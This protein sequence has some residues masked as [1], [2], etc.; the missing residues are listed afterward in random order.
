MTTSF[1]AAE[2]ALACGTSL[3]KFLSKYYLAEFAQAGIDGFLDFGKDK[4][5]DRIKDARSARKA[6]LAFEGVGTEVLERL[7]SDL[8]SAVLGM[9]EPRPDPNKILRRLQATLTGG[10]ATRFVIRNQIDPQKLADALREATSQS[11]E[12]L[13]EAEQRLFDD[14]ASRAAQY[15]YRAASKLP[16]FDEAREEESIAT[17][18][19]LANEVSEVL[20]DARAIRELVVSRPLSDDADYEISYRNAVVAELDK[21]ELF[22]VDL[23]PELKESRLTDAY[24]TLRLRPSDEDDEDDEPVAAYGKEDRATVTAEEAFNRLGPLAGRLLVRGGAGC[25]KTTLVRWA[26]IQA[27]RGTSQERRAI[28]EFERTDDG[29][30]RLLMPEEQAAIAADWRHRM[31][32]VITLRNCPDGRLPPP[33][34]FPA[35]IGNEVGNPTPQWVQRLLQKGQALVLIDGIDEVPR[36]N[37][38]DLYNSLKRLCEAFP[39]NYFVLTTRPDAVSG[40]RFEDLDFVPSEIEPL[41]EADRELFVRHWFQAVAQ[42]LKLSA[43]KA[44]E[45]NNEAVSVTKEIL[46][47]PWLA[48]LATT[49]LYCAMTC[50]LYRARRGSPPQGLR[51]MCETLC[52]MMVDRRDRER[53]LPFE[54]FPASYAKLDYPQKKLILRRLAYHLVLGEKSAIPV[55]D[56]IE[57]VGKTLAG[58]LQ[59]FESEAGQVFEM[60]LVR[61]GMLRLATPDT[62]ERPANVQFVHNTFKEFLAGEQLADEANASFLVKQLSDETWRRVGLFAISAGTAKYQNDVLRAVLAG[63][64]E[65]LPK[66]K[67]K[68]TITDAEVANM[69]RGRA[70]FAYRCGVLGNEWQVDIKERLNRLTRELFPPRTVSEA[71]WLA[72][73]GDVVVPLLSVNPNS[74]GYVVAACVR[75]LRLIGTPEALHSLEEFKNDN[76]ANVMAE[77]CKVFPPSQLGGVFWH[78]QHGLSLPNVIAGSLTDLTAVDHLNGVQNLDLRNTPVADLTPLREFTQLA[79]LILSDTQVVDLTPLQHLARLQSL[80]LSRTQVADLTPLQHLAQLQS[81]DLR[82]TQVVDLTPLQHLA[83]LQSLNLSGTQVVDLTPLLQLKH[84]GSLTLSQPS[85]VDLMPLCRLTKLESVDLSG[86]QVVDLSPLQHLANLRSLSLRATSVVDL[87]PLHQLKQLRKLYLW[88]APVTDVEPLRHLTQ[89]EV[90]SLPGTQVVDVTPLQHLAN[91]RSLLLWDTPVA[92]VAPLQHLALLSSLNLAGTQVTDLTPLQQLVRLEFLDLQRTRV[93]DTTPLQ[94][95]S[96]LQTL[97]LWGTLVTDLTPL[98]HPANHRLRII[99]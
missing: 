88:K 60:L 8:Q 56:A 95:L 52:E 5:K 47:T 16:Q 96:Q 94:H 97:N 31:P 41:E 43:K 69:P 50:A 82:N 54:A 80:D 2:L 4:L 15:L 90:L 87:T 65:P 25:G 13:T 55:P 72:S 32:F 85:V 40:V 48:Q 73:A 89:L 29:D 63:I 7:E 33:E 70:I 39:R 99:M 64:P 84:L 42:K 44:Q 38:L 24:V 45:L 75:A 93:A 22:G 1:I 92:D 86:E 21:V 27:A 53:K 30:I 3:G 58:M 67:K 76:R 10:L 66:D 37:H 51:A 61:S 28:P 79:T 59:R 71:E 23:P 78:L 34:Q 17:L 26:A 9:E 11:P 19:Q 46:R 81:L 62:D 49:P 18:A 35:Q 91:L 68:K 83:Q 12:L 14:F 6:E 20:E 98:Q 77:L 57:Q 36:L 74:N